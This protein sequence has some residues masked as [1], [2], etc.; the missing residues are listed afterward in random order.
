MF[1]GVGATLVVAG[2]VAFT[3]IAEKKKEVS[4]ETCNETSCT[5]SPDC[6]PGDAE[7][8]CPLECMK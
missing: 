7:C 6:K 4:S 3:S 8:I 2:A 5:V 1:M